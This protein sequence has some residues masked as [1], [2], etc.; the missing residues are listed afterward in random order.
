MT[1]KPPSVG[2]AA[3]DQELDQVRRTVAHMRA[4]LAALEAEIMAGDAQA[5]RESAKVL[6]DLRAWSKLAIEAETRFEERRKDQE[7]V[8]NGYALDLEDAERT[9]G[10]RLARLRRCCGAGGVSE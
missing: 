2:D 4:Q 1:M 8:V 7:G 9:I 5:I 10:C 6:A 3:L